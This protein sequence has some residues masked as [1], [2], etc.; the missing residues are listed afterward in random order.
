MAKK[1]FVNYKVQ[2]NTVM[3]WLD[4]IMQ[5][6]I[7]L[8]LCCRRQFTHNKDFWI[9]RNILSVLLKQKTL[10]RLEMHSEFK[11]ISDSPFD[12]TLY[13]AIVSRN[14]VII[15]NSKTTQKFS[16]SESGLFQHQNDYFYINS[17]N[18]LEAI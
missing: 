16:V 4:K 7:C 1:R 11:L 2:N 3:R 6:L 10:R 18:K 8:D 17:F 5:I 14:N 12:V 15:F 13:R 9:S